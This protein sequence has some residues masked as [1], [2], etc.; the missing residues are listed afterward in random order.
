M[1]IPKI[2]FQALLCCKFHIETQQCKQQEIAEA[3]YQKYVAGVY[4]RVVL[5]VVLGFLKVYPKYGQYEYLTPRQHQGLMHDCYIRRLVRRGIDH[6]ATVMVEISMEHLIHPNE[7][8]FSNRASLPPKNGCRKFVLQKEI[9]HVF[10]DHFF[11][12]CDVS[13]LQ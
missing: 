10:H 3:I 6:L 5:W 11:C 9:L 12:W 13:M 2:G 1:V 8:F 4:G 7:G